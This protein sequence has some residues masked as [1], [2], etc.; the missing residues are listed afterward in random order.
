MVKRILKITAVM[1]STLLLWGCEEKISTSSWGE[2]PIPIEIRIAVSDKEGNNML[3]PTKASNIS[4][5]EISASFLGGTYLRDASPKNGISLWTVKDNNDNPHVL[6]F[7]NIPGATNLDSV[8][9]VIDW[10]D[11]TSDTITIYNKYT[12]SMDKAPVLERHI[13]HDGKDYYG[14]PNVQVTR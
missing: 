9:L 10:G 8:P 3:D 1:L 6:V 11:G 14:K 2:M 7:G 12:W 13:I 4:S 5:N